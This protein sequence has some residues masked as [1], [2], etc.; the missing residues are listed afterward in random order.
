M[1]FVR[2]QGGISHHPAE[3]VSTA[4]VAAAIEVLSRF[5]TRLPII[6]KWVMLAGQAV[7]GRQGTMA[8]T[9]RTEV[10]DMVR[11]PDRLQS[12]TGE[13]I[14]G[15]EWHQEASGSLAQCSEWSRIVA[16]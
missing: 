9:E 2:C 14:V 3:S 10:W 15:T 4:D 1:L 12:D 8:R 16:V 7:N 11:I 6:G 13:S 5:L